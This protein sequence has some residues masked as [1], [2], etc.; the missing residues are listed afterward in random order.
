MNWAECRR[1]PNDAISLRGRQDHC[2]EGQGC[3]FPAA[4]RSTQAKATDPRPRTYID[5]E[6]QR[7][8]ENLANGSASA[9]LTKEGCEIA[10]A[11]TRAEFRR[12]RCSSESLGPAIT[13]IIMG[14]VKS[15]ATIRGMITGNARNCFS[16]SG[17]RAHFWRA[18]PAMCLRSRPMERASRRAATAIRPMR[19]LARWAALTA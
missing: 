15:L 11:V 2:R 9:P 4:V 5:V 7:H 14:C 3:A 10:S 12:V 6:S 18:P 19:S 17:P 1:P 8:Q 16:L 13:A